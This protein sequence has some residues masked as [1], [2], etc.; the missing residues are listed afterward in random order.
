[1]AENE[2]I[3]SQIQVDNV[4]YDIYDVKALR[5]NADSNYTLAIK[6]QSNESDIFTVD[7]NGTTALS[8]GKLTIKATAGYTYLIHTTDG[9]TEDVRYRLGMSGVSVP[10]MSASTDGGATYG[11]VFYN[12]LYAGRAANK[13]LASP[14]GS[15]G[16][17]SFRALVAADLPTVTRAKGGTGVTAK[18]ASTV[19]LSDST[20]GTNYCWHNGVLATVTLGALKVSSVLNDSA[21]RKIGNVPANYRPASTVYAVGAGSNDALNGKVFIMIGSNGD[22]TLYNR[23]G[24]NIATTASMYFTVTYAI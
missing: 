24:A 23:T 18:Q 10:D 5:S 21:N 20:A 7:W 13:V 8:T 22:V 1:M 4:T 17:A 15:T 14:N 9:T 2:N 3:I 16:A 11:T 12:A 6:D 19:T